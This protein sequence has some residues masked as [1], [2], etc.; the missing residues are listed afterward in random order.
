MEDFVTESRVVDDGSGVYVSE[1]KLTGPPRTHTTRGLK[2]F[3]GGHYK[4]TK[5]PILGLRCSFGLHT[6]RLSTGVCP[7][8]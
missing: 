6:I 1:S 5:V 8:H 3:R 2:N 4:C 7:P